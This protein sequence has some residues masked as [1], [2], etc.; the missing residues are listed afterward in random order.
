M[1]FIKIK[2][3]FK[4]FHKWDEA[5]PSKAFLRSL[6][7]HLF[8]V[9]AKIQ[10]LHNDRELEFFAVQEQLEALISTFKHHDCGS[11]EM[12]AERFLKGLE[13][14]YPDRFIE[15][16]VSEDGENAGIFDNVETLWKKKT[17]T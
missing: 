16:S 3:Q 17:K 15:V 7:R 4:G 8:L 10:V 6:H 14:K 9:E 1:R 11:C 2:S 5:P 12:I 13:E